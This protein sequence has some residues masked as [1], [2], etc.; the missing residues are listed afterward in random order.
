MFQHHDDI[1]DYFQDLLYGQNMNF[2]Q[3]GHLIIINTFFNINTDVKFCL[4]QIIKCYILKLLTF[5][6]GSQ[7]QK[8]INP[9]FSNNEK[10]QKMNE[11]MNND[12]YLLEIEE[13]M[14]IEENN[15]SN[16]FLFLTTQIDNSSS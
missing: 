10:K 6:T 14:N 5:K 16:P 2:N 8:Q 11:R 7:F 1:A 9:S 15:S 13:F 4:K 12:E 3:D